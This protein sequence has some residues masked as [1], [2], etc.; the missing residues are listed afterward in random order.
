[1]RTNA[2]NESSSVHGLWQVFLMGVLLLWGVGHALIAQ[3]LTITV[4]DQ[5]GAP[6]PTKE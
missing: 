6:S 1:M 5:N 4:V 2:L 3:A